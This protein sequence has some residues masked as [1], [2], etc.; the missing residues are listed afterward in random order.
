MSGHPRSKPTGRQQTADRYPRVTAAGNAG[1]WERRKAPEGQPRGCPGTKVLVLLSTHY[2]AMTTDGGSKRVNGRRGQPRGT[3]GLPERVDVRCPGA[4]L[5]TVSRL[6][7]ASLPG[8]R[9]AAGVVAT[10]ATRPLSLVGALGTQC[11]MA[12]SPSA[13]APSDGVLPRTRGP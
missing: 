13:A 1:L 7:A 4:V 12:R 2:G 6:A 8:G 9:G 5:T 11:L 3:P 10:D